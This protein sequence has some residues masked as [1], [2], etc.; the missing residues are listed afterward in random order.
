MSY[1]FVSFSMVIFASSLSDRPPFCL[2]LQTVHIRSYNETRLKNHITD[3]YRGCRKIPQESRD[4]IRSSDLR[5]QHNVAAGNVNVGVGV[6]VMPTLPPAKRKRSDGG[7]LGGA[8]HH[9]QNSASAAAVAAVAAAV[10]GSDGM[11]LN[12]QM[13]GPPDPPSPHVRVAVEFS[14]SSGSLLRAT[15]IAAELIT[16][17]HRDLVEVGL[18]PSSSTEDTFN[19]WIGGKVA[20]SRVP[21][22][23]LPDYDHLRPIV[24]AVVGG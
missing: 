23:P 2:P 16:E 14:M 7:G 3:P 6:G 11:P 22:A 12:V 17:F 21:G 8:S 9:N 4:R 15:W 13:P 1:I 18:M 19:I 24:R 20:W 5:A 10:S